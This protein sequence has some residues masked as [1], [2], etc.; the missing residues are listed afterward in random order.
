MSVQRNEKICCD[1]GDLPGWSGLEKPRLTR[2]SRSAGFR[3]AGL[4]VLL[5]LLSSCDDPA[6]NSGSGKTEKGAA[7]S[8]EVALPA[9]ESST[10]TA[11]LVKTA[12]HPSSQTTPDGQPV[13][14]DQY[15]SNED[16]IRC[17][18]RIGKE[19]SGSMHSA[20]FRDPFFRALYQMAS[21]DTEGKTDRLCMGCHSS[22]LVISGHGE[23]SKLDQFK[24]PVTD[25][26]SCV[27]CHFID[28]TNLASEEELPANASFVADP[29]GPIHGP[30]AERRCLHRGRA[31]VASKQM[32]SS[33]FC[34]N[35]HRVVHPNNGLVVDR[36]Y[37]EWL[38][39]IYAE[40]GIQCQDCHMRPVELAIETARTLKKL[41]N[42]GRA[43]EKSP[44]R[45]HIS[46]HYFAGANSAITS[47]QGAD[48]HAAMAE[49]LLKSAASL[50]LIIPEP[51]AN[52]NE[53]AFDVRVTNETAG[54]NLPTSLTEV[55]QMW[56]DVEV[57]DA[58]GKV[59]YRSGAI[60]EQGNI[61]P[62]A[63]MFHSVGIDKQG[64]ETIK[65]WQMVKFVSFH[66]IPPR[67]SLLEHYRFQIASQVTKPLK[68][69]VT[70]RYRSYSQK[71]ARL[72]LGEDTPTVPVV[73]MVS[74]TQTL[75]TP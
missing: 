29:K 50:K 34:G 64:N 35:C 70:L 11:Q 74:L 12:F 27:V 5:F 31:T 51:A 9:N 15:A 59:I 8:N 65:P 32:R 25:G 7:P 44:M 48:E 22:P 20:G 73:D 23:N 62:E 41:K 56:L 46:S 6:S 66:T 2:Y 19:W 54:H 71:L 57:S 13:A 49:E 16:C 67:D 14:L 3:G 69:R 38:G 28:R 53:I 40:K 55:R 43:T 45:E 30:H 39:S 33:K 24:S 61:D 1:N 42:P 52:S 26:I 4:V 18:K 37:E 58:Q 72:L 47:L 17:H 60:D 21:E 10:E 75:E 68:V 63:V 36:T